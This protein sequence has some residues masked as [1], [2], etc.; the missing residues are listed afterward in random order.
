M[1][2]PEGTIARVAER[3]VVLRGVLIMA[4]SVS[5]FPVTDAIAKHL[6][7]DYHVIEIAVVRSGLLMLAVLLEL[8]RR[9]ALRLVR[10]RRPGLQALRGLWSVLSVLTFLT[11][12]SFVPLLDSIAIS[13]A[14]PLFM[15]ALS[16]PLLGERV[17]AHRWG[18]VV[19]GFAGVLLML[20][21]GL[22]VVH[23]AASL[24]LA[25]ALASA[26]YQITTRALARHD[27]TL[28]SLFYFGLTGTLFLCLAA[29]F[30]WRPLTLEAFGWMALM[31]LLGAIGHF[32]VIRALEH[33]PVAVVAPL[34]YAQILCAA[35]LGY[36]AFGDVPDA[37][38]IAGLMV[39]ILSGLYVFHR[40]RR[41]SR[42]KAVVPGGT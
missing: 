28:T 24:A 20:R 23:W 10:T 41:L 6:S 5:I 40:E 7:S 3:P 42:R 36:F 27:Q 30:V 17:G 34:V 26:L 12:I 8:W 25:S 32:G 33:A 38:T 31:G 4:A 29:P 21:P 15:V 35:M 18:A 19:V 11:A 13:F 14:S 39:V 16:V 37:W 2:A 1:S 9:N 22:G